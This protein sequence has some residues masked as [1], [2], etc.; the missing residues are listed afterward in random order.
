MTDPNAVT[1]TTIGDH[2]RGGD[3]DESEDSDDD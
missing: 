1:R 3:G 2:G